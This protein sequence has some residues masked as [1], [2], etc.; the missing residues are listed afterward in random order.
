MRAAVDLTARA[1]PPEGRARLQRGTRRAF[2]NQRRDDAGLRTGVVGNALLLAPRLVPL[3][4]RVGRWL[5]RCA[6]A[7]A[8]APFHLGHAGWSATPRRRRV[9]WRDEK[10]RR[11]DIEPAGEREERGQS[12][13]VVPGFDRL[14]IADGHACALGK[15]ALG[16]SG[17]PPQL[18][19]STAEGALFDHGV[20][21]LLHGSRIARPVGLESV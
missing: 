11:S 2:E 9:G 16:S 12:R 19:H 6:A 14:H 20:G 18:R 17:L 15:R 4:C 5:C 21:A 10:F 13:V 8:S 3:T 7:H 1:A